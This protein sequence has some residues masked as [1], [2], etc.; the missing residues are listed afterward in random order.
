MNVNIACD[1]RFKL[2]TNKSRYF[3]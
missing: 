2:R 1:L 3:S